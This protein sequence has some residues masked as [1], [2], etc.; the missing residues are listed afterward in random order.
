MTAAIAE[1]PLPP[2]LIETCLG[3]VVK[4][5]SAQP[6]LTDDARRDMR[7]TIRKMIL[8]LTPNDATQLMLAGQAMLFMTLAANAAFDLLN[9]MADAQKPRAQ[10]HVIALG[11]LS[12]RHM[13]RLIRLRTPSVRAKAKPVPL[14]PPAAVS[15]PAAQDSPPHTGT[16]QDVTMAPAAAPIG[17]TPVETPVLMSRAARRAAAKLWRDRSGANYVPPRTSSRKHKLA[18]EQTARLMRAA[19]A[20]PARSP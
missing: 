16:C 14:H 3:G 2:G 6:G 17:A 1:S 11:R 7:E 18:A 9:G 4:A 15:E 5:L 13:D 19:M 10:A 20:A 12:A 8:A